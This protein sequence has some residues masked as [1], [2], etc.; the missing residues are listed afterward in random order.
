MTF[1]KSRFN[2]FFIW[3]SLFLLITIIGFIP[4]FLLRPL[5]KET[6]IPSYFILHGALMLLWF[7]GFFHQNFLIA[8]GKLINHKKNGIGWFILA[9]LVALANFNVLI[10]MSGEVIDGKESYYGVVRTVK[11]T[12]RLILGNLY[13]NLSSAILILIGYIKRKN[14]NVHKRA[15]FGACVF[16]LAPALDRFMR[17]FNLEEFHPALN[18]IIFLFLIP[19]SLIIYDLIRYRRLYLISIIILLILIFIIP[20]ITLGIEYQL[21]RSI[22]EFLG[23]R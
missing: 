3:S 9:F 19:I 15:L 2:F 14:P 13:L 22:I 8:K 20:L 1:R 11:N 18:F 17:P 7:L 10:R 5:F 23:L 16:L 21:D 6:G 12:G 4:S